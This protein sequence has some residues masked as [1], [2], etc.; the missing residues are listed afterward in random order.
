MQPHRQPSRLADR[1]IRR[2]ER[3]RSSPLGRNTACRFTP[4]CSHYAEEA[5]RGRAF[6]VASLLIAWRLLR[7]N[8]FMHQHVADPVRRS[9]RWRLRPNTLP[10]LFSVLALSGFVVVIT[11]GVAAAV[12]VSNGCTATL[13]GKSPAALDSDNPL[14]VHKGESVRFVGTVP[15]SVQ[16]APKDQLV[17]NTHID[18]D[19]IGGVFGVTSSDHPGHGPIWGGQESVDK[20]LKYGVGLYHVTGKA[21]GGPGNWTCDG[22]A[23]LQLKDGSPLGKPVGGGAAALTAL[24]A[25]GALLSVRASAP[26][27]SRDPSR[28][29]T[30]E[31]DV[32]REQEAT[33]YIQDGSNSLA[34]SFGC[35]TLILIAIGATFIYSGLG[36]AALGGAGLSRSAGRRVWSHGHPIMGFISGLVFAIG[37]TVLLQQFAV[38][39]LTIVTAIVFPVVVAIICS[40]RAWLG[41][42]YKLKGA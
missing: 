11:A 18:V 26:D 2:I 32:D 6:P 19:I 38:W 25:V 37:F 40:L 1:A 22:D 9:R 13:N 36:A 12:G 41:Q 23:Y 14:V 24:G 27:A 39:P 16:S 31:E 15:A 17:S 7:C 21:T 30:D 20:Y 5:L 34:S 8:P 42:P 28:I 29:A 35:L 3:Y 4:S 33:E 10:T